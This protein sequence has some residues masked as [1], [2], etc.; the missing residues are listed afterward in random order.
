M[1]TALKGYHTLPYIV[2]ERQTR[3]IAEFVGYKWSY[4]PPHETVKPVKRDMIAF[5]EHFCF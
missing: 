5:R 3:H 2:K 1:K 4:L